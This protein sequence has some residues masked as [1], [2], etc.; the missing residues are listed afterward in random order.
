[1]TLICNECDAELKRPDLLDHS[2]VSYL[3]QLNKKYLEEINSLEAGMQK[4]Q[5]QNEALTSQNAL[6][7]STEIKEDQSSLV[8]DETKESD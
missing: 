6:L 3:K 5:T 4:L 8:E 1:M 2:C 7:K